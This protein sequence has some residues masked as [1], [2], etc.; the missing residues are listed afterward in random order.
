MNE[1]D[2]PGRRLRPLLRE[3]MG[4][5]DKLEAAAVVTGDGLPLAE[6]LGDAVDRER[7]AAM[8]SSLLALADRAAD[9]MQRGKL[10][11]LMIE[12]EKGTML[13]VYAGPHAVLAVAAKPEANLGRVFLE[14]RTAASRV[15]PLLPLAYG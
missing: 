8:S 4:R 11:Q 9:E 1:P 5:S 14:A 15:Q 3:L 12:G 10:R 13:L 6:V 7:F 2:D